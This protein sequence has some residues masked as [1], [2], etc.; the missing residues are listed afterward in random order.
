MSVAIALAFL[1][2]I[3]KSLNHLDRY[4]DDISAR[5]RFAEADRNLQSYRRQLVT[6]R[7]GKAAYAGGRK[8]YAVSNS[9]IF[10]T[11]RSGAQNAPPAR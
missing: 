6:A 11:G 3:G 7:I 10:K 9:N 1:S 5:A 8:A 2:A 4:A